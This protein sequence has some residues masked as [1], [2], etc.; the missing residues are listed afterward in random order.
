MLLVFPSPQGT[1]KRRN[2]ERTPRPVN[3]FGCFPTNFFLWLFHYGAI[4][5]LLCVKAKMHALSSVFSTVLHIFISSVFSTAVFG[6]ALT[7]K[8]LKAVQ[9]TP[10]E[11]ISISLAESEV[12]N[13]E[14]IQ[15]VLYPKHH[16]PDC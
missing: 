7:R 5:N 6:A 1:R 13:H 9:I 16:V 12:R 10:E 11:K 3:T 2:E 8:F 4:Q 15:S 14:E